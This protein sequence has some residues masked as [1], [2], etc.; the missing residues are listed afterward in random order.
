M[1]RPR[2]R[3]EESGKFDF[4]R[5]VLGWT[6]KV[7][8]TRDEVFRAAFMMLVDELQEACPKDTFFLMSS[9]EASTAGTPPMT[10]KNPAPNAPA[11]SFS[12]DRGTIVGVVES[13]EYGQKL[14]LGYTAEYAGMVHDGHGSYAGNPWVSLVTQRWQAIVKEAAGRIGDR[15]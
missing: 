1:A 15:A 14:Y 9:L 6:R 11:G 7:Y 10:R 5:Q 3:I 2:R 8:K 12:F 13:A 4:G